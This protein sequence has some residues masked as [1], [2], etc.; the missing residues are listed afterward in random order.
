MAC[1]IRRFTLAGACVVVLAGC[2]NGGVAVVRIGGVPHATITRSTLD[3][4]M[5]ATVGGDFRQIIGQ[6]G[7]QGLVSE[8]VNYPRCINAAKLVAP[9]SFFN[10]LQLTRERLTQICQQ[11]HRA[12]KAQALSYLISARWAV[13]EG[14][15]QGVSVSDAEVKQTFEQTRGRQYP[16]ERALRDYL[17]ERQ[18]SLADLFDHLRQHLLAKRLGRP[19]GRKLLAKTICAPADIVPNCSAYRGPARVSPTPSELIT[20]LVV[21]AS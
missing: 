6:Q 17:S 4:W 10:Q 9:R 7:P 2:G 21:K 15:E 13:L 5:R 3:H 1:A 11:L 19:L 14:A 20:H 16:T 8:P 12:I 18:W